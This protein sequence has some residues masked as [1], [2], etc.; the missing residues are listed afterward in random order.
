VEEFSFTTKDTKITKQGL[1]ARKKGM[2]RE[3]LYLVIGNCELLIV[4]TWQNGGLER[5][6]TETIAIGD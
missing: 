5:R 3:M 4:E 6:T 2:K 1:A